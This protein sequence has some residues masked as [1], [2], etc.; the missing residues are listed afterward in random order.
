MT[1]YLYI[2]ITIFAEIWELV[3]NQGKK[4]ERVKIILFVI[5]ECFIYAVY[6]LLEKLR[7]KKQKYRGRA[8]VSPSKLIFHFI[9]IYLITYVPLLLW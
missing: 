6:T 2:I 1:L 9:C 8:V 5:N 4:G 3:Y 7:K